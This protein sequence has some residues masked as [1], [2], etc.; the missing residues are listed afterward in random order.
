MNLNLDIYQHVEQSG[1]GL[2]SSAISVINESTS[3][4]SEFDALLISE[5]LSAVNQDLISQVQTSILEAKADLT[6]VSNHVA[7]NLEKTLSMGSVVHQVNQVNALVEG[8][9]AEAFNTDSVMG[10][11][12]GHANESIAAIA[13]PADQGIQAVAD[14]TNGVIDATDF[15]LILTTFME[16][17]N[18]VKTTILDVINAEKNEWNSVINKLN[19]SSQAQAITALWK[20][21][22][23][24]TLLEHTLPP[25]IKQYL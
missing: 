20:H 22:S 4:L 14:Y 18:S 12:M 15:E 11:V 13:A 9:V 23:T 7:A 8:S 6:T 1:L 17:V 3:A 25:E 2:S 10:T 19:A 21:P 16:D 5:D 24:Q